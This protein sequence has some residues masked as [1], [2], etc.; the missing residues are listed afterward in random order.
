MCLCVGRTG[1]LGDCWRSAMQSS[2]ILH[3][4]A[5]NAASTDLTD[6]HLHLCILMSAYMSVCLSLPLCPP[7]LC[8]VLEYPSV[9]LFVC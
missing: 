6:L 4:A 3:N 1:F 5:C 9:Y 2:A 7:S 8:D